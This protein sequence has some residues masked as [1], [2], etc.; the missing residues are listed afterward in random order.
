MRY[1][2]KVVLLSALGI[3]VL[4]SVASAQTTLRFRFTEGEK[5]QYEMEQKTI[6]TRNVM[7]MDVQ[8]KTILKRDLV[9]HIVAVNRDGS[10]QVQIKVI[11]AKMALDGVTGM[12]DVDSMDKDDPADPVR[13]AASQQVKAMAATEL[14]GTIQ[15]TGEM[16]LKASAKTIEDPELFKAM[17]GNIIFPTAAVAKG[18]AWSKTQELKTALGKM[19]ID[20]SYA[21]EGTVQKDGVMLE[22]ISIKPDIKIEPMPNSPIKE[23]KEAKGSGQILFDNKSGRLI[24]SVVNQYVQMEAVFGG[25]NGQQTSDQTTT[26]RLK[27]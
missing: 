22:K 9:W 21:Y 13:K 18:K 7:N 17:I 16:N 2:M 8:A 12:L 11:R 5:L 23:I 10:A 14:S 24:E 27:K 25:I 20:N 26:L 1:G 19:T 6:A 15:P 3:A 4:S